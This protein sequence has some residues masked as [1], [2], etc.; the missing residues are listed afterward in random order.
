MIFCINIEANRPPPEPPPIKEDE[1][2][3]IAFFPVVGYTEIIS[4]LGSL[5]VA[6][7]TGKFNKSFSVACQTGPISSST[8]SQIAGRV[9]TVAELANIIAFIWLFC[10]LSHPNVALNAVIVMLRLLI[11]MFLVTLI[12]NN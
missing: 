1:S 3:W 7:K 9:Y 10:S 6:G 12:N 8:S 11:V 4:A 2:E 5:P